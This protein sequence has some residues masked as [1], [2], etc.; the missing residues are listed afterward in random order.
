MKI[1]LGPTYFSVTSGIRSLRFRDQNY[2]LGMLDPY[3][4]IRNTRIRNP[5]VHHKFYNVF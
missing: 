5:V 3:P 1:K 4:Y 2:F